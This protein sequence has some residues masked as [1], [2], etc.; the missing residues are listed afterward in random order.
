MTGRVRALLAA[1]LAAGGAA[2]ATATNYSD[3]AGP[4]YAA[5]P[6]SAPPSDT[7]HVVAF[8]V[9]YAQ[10]VDSA[11][12]LL[13]EDSSLR[14]A[15]LVLLQEMDEPG[16][17]RI[18]AALGLGYVYYPATRSPNTGRDFGNAILSRWPLE[19][20]RKI[21]LPHRARIG[22]TQ[23]AAVAATLRVRGVAVRVYSVHLATMLGNGPGSRRDQL[24]TVLV[25][26]DRYP[27]VILG[28]DFNSE[29]VPE[30]A[31]DRGFTW[32]T[33]RLPR[34][35]VFWTF[36]HV[37]LKGLAPAGPAAF[38][39]VSEVRGSSDHRP[40]WIRIPLP[41]AGGPPGA[42]AAPGEAAYRAVPPVPIVLSSRMNT[43]AGAG[44]Q[45]RPHRKA[46]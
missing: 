19:D 20:D 28:G 29:T 40:V 7:L 27:V 18:A 5:A 14:G 41:A 31:L 34:T 44:Y 43:T 23:R 9:K 3:A 30:V 10:R 39:V 12:A 25:D 6:V 46:V 21:V 35:S 11:I 4:R 2:C 42:S 15:D 1:V 32:P 22:G 38:G 45:T 16:T 8:N 26:A 17:R 13:T 36:D 33:R 24:R 37:L